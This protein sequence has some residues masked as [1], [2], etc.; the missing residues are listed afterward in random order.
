M[1]KDVS[2]HVSSAEMGVKREANDMVKFHNKH[3]SATISS[4]LLPNICCMAVPDSLTELILL[5]ILSACHQKQKNKNKI[6]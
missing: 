2:Q 1:V 3:T 6:E 4:H 5:F